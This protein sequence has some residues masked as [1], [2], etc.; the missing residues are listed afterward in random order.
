M[1]KLCVHI[2]PSSTY[3]LH[4]LRLTFILILNLYIGIYIIR[5]IYCIGSRNVDFLQVF[6]TIVLPSTKNRSSLHERAFR[7][8]V[9]RS[10]PPSFQ[11]LFPSN[12]ILVL[13]ISLLQKAGLHRSD[14]R[15]L[16]MNRMMIN[17]YKGT[18]MVYSVK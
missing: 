3:P 11:T 14:E 13:R 5:Y 12:V 18:E 16:D 7:P 15:A 2:T 9:T 6:I 17:E 4:C 1:L 8:F 10:F